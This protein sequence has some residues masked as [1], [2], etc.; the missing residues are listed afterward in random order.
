[1][2]R[3]I[4]GQDAG[5]TIVG[6]LQGLRMIVS[7]VVCVWAGNYSGGAAAGCMVCLPSLVQPAVSHSFSVDV[8]QPPNN[9]P[10]PTYL[11]A[12]KSL[13]CWMN[14][15]YVCMLILT[16]MHRYIG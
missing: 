4:L 8:R 11:L 14:A 9:R 6:K 15:A 12:L 1:M 3:Q 7:T 2:V 13:E 5:W 16:T 10:A